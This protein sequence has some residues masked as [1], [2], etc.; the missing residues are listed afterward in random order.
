M[1]DSGCDMFPR[2]VVKR[3]D[4]VSFSMY[5]MVMEPC[6]HFASIIMHKPIVDVCVNGRRFQHDAMADSSDAVAMDMATGEF[7]IL[8]YSEW[9]QS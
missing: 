3:S 1:K 7:V 4:A 5:P 8:D 2:L 9:M 6:C